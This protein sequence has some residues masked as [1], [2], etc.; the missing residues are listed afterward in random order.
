MSHDLQG[1]R[2][3]ATLKSGHQLF[4]HSSNNRSRL[5]VE[6]YRVRA[7]ESFEAVGRRYQEAATDVGLELVAI[8]GIS[9]TMLPISHCE[10]RAEIPG[11]E[12]H[13]EAST[14]PSRYG[15]G[16]LFFRSHIL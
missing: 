12:K 11:G 4:V 14:T 13:T 1:E 9:M 16:S 15:L 2:L 5:V 6:M 10:S 8:N 7:D 3:F